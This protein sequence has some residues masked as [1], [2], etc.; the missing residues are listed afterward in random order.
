MSGRG[1]RDF[2]HVAGMNVETEEI[3]VG[4]AQKNVVV[5]H[6]REDGYEH[7]GE[8]LPYIRR[9]SLLEAVGASV[10]F[11]QSLKG[12]SDE[13]LIAHGRDTLG[14]LPLVAAVVSD[15]VIIHS[16]SVD[17]EHSLI[18]DKHPD[19]TIAIAEYCLHPVVG[20]YT[21]ARTQAHMGKHLAT[22]VVYVYTAV[23]TNP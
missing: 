23:C 9:P 21:L 22:H 6:R 11:K 1:E 2:T 4:V 15:A 16:L 12:C 14:Q 19:I 10:V 20:G 17:S 3:A 18:G 13:N 8:T 7:A 5:G